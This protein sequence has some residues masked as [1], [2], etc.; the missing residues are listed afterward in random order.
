MTVR[1]NLRS[2]ASLATYVNGYPFKPEEHSG[3]GLPIVRIRQLNDPAAEC[4]YFDGYVPAR[5]HIKNGDLIFSWSGSLSVGVWD[6]GHALLNQHLFKVLPNPDV[7]KRWLRWL[8]FVGMDLFDPY[9]HGSAMTHITQPMMRDV[10]VGLP[11]LEEQRRIADF[12]DDQ[13]TRIDQAI[14]L[15]Q[16]QALS[17]NQRWISEID[18]ATHR[19]GTA[20]RLKWLVRE[21]DDRAGATADAADLLSVSI[22]H[23]V[24]PRRT[25]TDDPPRA[26]SLVNYKRVRIGDLV[27]NR[28]RA[29]QGGIGI[30]GQFGV[31]SPDYAVLRPTPDTAAEY[32][33]HMFRSKWFVAEMTSRL[34]GIGGIDQGT[35][36]TPRVN[37]DDLLNTEIALPPLDKQ[38]E[39]AARLDDRGAQIAV[40]G[41][42]LT[43]SIALLQERKRSLITAAVTG[44]FDVSAA[45]RQF[46][47]VPTATGGVHA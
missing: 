20:V 33:H 34:R 32:L 4:D 26:D 16:Q 39:V 43:R 47:E 13:T 23:G 28:M 36:R 6:R 3:E 46:D 45:R 42:R 7:D 5:N 8:L 31:V 9:M 44:E 37:V 27:L 17:L 10:K 21:V 22:H 15:R 30:S 11:S 38:R 1:W 14:Q 24:V 35:V 19:R 41:E 29:F 18:S 2:V 12:L 25:I 40:A